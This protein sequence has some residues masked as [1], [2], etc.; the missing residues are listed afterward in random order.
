MVLNLWCY[1][2]DD[3]NLQWY[4]ADESAILFPVGLSLEGDILIRGTHP[5]VSL[6]Y[7]QARIHA[8]T[9]MHTHTNTHTHSAAPG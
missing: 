5:V 6:A 9:H 8:R 1:A 4:D 2:Q 7:V 3:G